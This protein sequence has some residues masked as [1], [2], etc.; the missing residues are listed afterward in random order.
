MTVPPGSLT[1]GIWSMLSARESLRTRGYVS[2][3]D[4]T[5]V[6]SVGGYGPTV[7][8]SIRRRP[9]LLK[10]RIWISNSSSFRVVGGHAVK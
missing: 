7:P 4:A 6:V 2:N 1:I 8:T 9:F 5:D 10:I 3:F